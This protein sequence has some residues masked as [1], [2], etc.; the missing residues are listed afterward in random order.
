MCFVSVIINYNIII[1][2]MIAITKITF[3]DGDYDN[4]FYSG[5]LC[6]IKSS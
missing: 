1:M 4:R 2:V 6:V 5:F 3:Y